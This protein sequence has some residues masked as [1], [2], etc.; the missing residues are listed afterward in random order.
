MLG[1]PVERLL[2]RVLGVQASAVAARCLTYWRRDPRYLG[3][4]AVVPF[5]P[6][7]LALL[8]RGDG[9]LVLVACPLAAFLVGWTISADVAYD[10]SAFWAHLGAGL[11]G[12]PDRLGRAVAATLVGLPVA[13]AV[14]L[15]VV[16]STGRWQ[17]LAAVAGISVG[18]LLTAL[19]ISSVVSARFVYPVPRPGDGP[20]S[21]PQGSAVADLATQAGGW[22]VLVLLALPEVAVGVV[23]VVSGSAEARLAR[24]RARCGSGRVLVGRRCADRRG[25]LRPPR[26][27]AASAGGREPMTRPGRAQPAA[28]AFVVVA[29]AVAGASAVARG[30][31]TAATTATS[32]AST[33]APRYP[34]PPTLGTSHAMAIPARASKNALLRASAT[35][36]EEVFDPCSWVGE[37]SKTRIASVG[38]S[39]PSPRPPAAHAT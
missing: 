20:F 2:D 4:L 24:P 14:V 36:S 6:L 28:P 13:A 30:A 19:G 17:D 3:A 26:P 27:R 22:A 18:I 5:L 11:P 1:G 35:W 23:A 33:K 7:V 38:N 29:F 37:R 32:Q 10:H 16:A 12:R 25:G 9:G 15:G 8:D 34:T 39:M 31:T 21:S